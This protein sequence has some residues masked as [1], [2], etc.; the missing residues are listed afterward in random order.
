[1]AAYPSF[2]MMREGTGVTVDGGH[3]SAR[4]TNGALRVQRLF[5]SAKRQFDVT[6][7]LSAADKA[8][9][10]A[11]FTTN[12]DLDVTLTWPEDGASYTVRFIGEPQYLRR[13]PDLW[14]VTAK[15][16]EA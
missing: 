12:K 10:A 14:V 11:F 8:T 7:W 6:H 5:P 16:A 9:Y 1:M 2:T 15:L 4:A 13:N 3:R